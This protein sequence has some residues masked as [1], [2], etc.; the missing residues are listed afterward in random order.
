M[1][2]ERSRPTL[3]PNRRLKAITTPHPA[4]GEGAE[5]RKRSVAAVIADIDRERPEQVNLSSAI[6]VAVLD[7]ALTAEPRLQPNLEEPL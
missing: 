3:K 4:K 6:R 2:R 5:S 7:W 1:K